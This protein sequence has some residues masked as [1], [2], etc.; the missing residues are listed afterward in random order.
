MQKDF[1]QQDLID[2]NLSDSKRNEIDDLMKSGT[3]IKVTQNFNIDKKATVKAG[4]VLAFTSNLRQ[5]AELNISQ[6]ELKVITLILEIMEF[7]NLICINQS[8]IA[9]ELGLAKSNVSTVFKKLRAKNIL[10]EKNGH[11]FMNSALFQKGLTHSLTEERRDYLKD[12][13]N[14]VLDGDDKSFNLIKT[15]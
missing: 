3:N 7:G 9:K 8:A 12:A 10:I 6:N 1:T 4:F 13:Q 14:T 2:F 15:I 11:L 5:L